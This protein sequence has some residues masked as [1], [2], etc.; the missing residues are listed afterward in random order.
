MHYT[1][2]ELAERLNVSKTTIRKYMKNVPESVIAEHRYTENGTMYLSE[3]LCEDL[4]NA[5]R[6]A[7]EEQ[8]KR[9]E[10]VAETFNKSECFKETSCKLSESELETHE[11]ME[12]TANNTEIDRTSLEN[13]VQ[14]TINILKVEL[15]ETR[16]QLAVKDKQIEELNNRLSELTTAL[17]AAQTLHAADKR[18]IMIED[19]QQDP[20]H[21]QS[22]FARIFKKK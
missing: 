21:K 22:I 3:K 2:K 5:I 1:V 13:M 15:E 12:K 11:N 9:A 8:R 7:E 20:E 19:K 18:T 17:T 14:E 4:A 16:K 10:I 6:N